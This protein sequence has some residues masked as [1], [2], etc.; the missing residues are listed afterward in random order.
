MMRLPASMLRVATYYTNMNLPNFLTISR[1]IAIPFLIVALSYHYTGSAL[2]IFVAC[3]IT[4]GLDG[5]IARTFHQRTKIGAY[6]DPL[7]DKLLLTSTFI[8]LTILHLPNQ[9]PLWL[10]ITVI[11]RD[12]IISGG[13]AVLFM[14]GTEVQIQPTKIGKFTTFIQLTLI[15]VVLYYNYRGVTQAD[16]IQPLSWLTF[17]VSVASGLGYVYQGVEIL[18][19]TD[20]GMNPPANT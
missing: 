6:L 17:I 12:V 11:S 8:T 18:N 1:I 2:I 20:Q 5:F 3:G 15:V 19:A 9:L 4:D 7:A 13:I 16:I 14:L 10:I